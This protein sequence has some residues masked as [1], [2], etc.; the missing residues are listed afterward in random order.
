[1]ISP[2]GA[3]ASPWAKGALEGLHDRALG[4]ATQAP[5]D[6]VSPRPA[7]R[8][9]ATPI[10]Q[11]ERQRP[12]QRAPLRAQASG[13]RREAGWGDA[14][15][16]VP[17]ARLADEL[18][19]LASRPPPQPPSPTTR[20]WHPIARPSPWLCKLPPPPSWRERGRG[21]ADLGNYCRVAVGVAS[22]SAAG[23]LQLLPAT[24]SPT[25]AP[26][27]MSGKVSPAL[28]RGAGAPPS[29]ARLFLRFG[30]MP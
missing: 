14:R 28:L 16:S 4:R 8:R 3:R 25:G 27:V 23:E 6:A 2:S 12:R 10:P 13:G 24:S 5:A 26:R 15:H 7:S 20:R 1:M 11:K 18:P 21:G 17:Q 9:A 22:G 30:L 29:S 19:G